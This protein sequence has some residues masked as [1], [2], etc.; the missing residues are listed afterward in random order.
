MTC[1]PIATGRLFLGSAAEGETD[2]EHLAREAEWKGQHK[3]T[4][5]GCFE[6]DGD[7]QEVDDAYFT[8]PEPNC[9]EGRY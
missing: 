6:C 9:Q 5:C 8:M 1:V 4:I 2:E 7:C 3:C